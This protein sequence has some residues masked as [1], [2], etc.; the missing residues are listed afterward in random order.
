MS[1][2][3][4]HAIDQQCFNH[5]SLKGIM[6]SKCSQ[7]HSCILAYN[8]ALLAIDKDKVTPSG[9]QVILFTKGVTGTPK[10]NMIPYSSGHKIGGAHQYNT[11]ATFRV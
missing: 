4:Q 5:Q 1:T 3:F 7:S 11:L 2:T 8:K 10:D 9:S 6:G